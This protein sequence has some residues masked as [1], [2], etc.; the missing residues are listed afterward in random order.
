MSILPNRSLS[1]LR[2]RARQR[3]LSTVEYVIIL[4]LVAAVSLAT[5]K[6]FGERVKTAIGLSAARLDVLNAAQGGPAGDGSGTSGPGSGSGTSPGGPGAG[7]GG[8][9]NSTPSGPTV[10]TN[11]GSNID[12][13]VN[14]SPALAQDV[15]ALK[16]AGW[17]IRYTTGTRPAASPTRTVS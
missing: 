8:P 17:T 1:L 5:W 16:A 14:Q 2:R 7:P 12:A 9:R 10:T 15:Q 3:G 11:L 13:V 6:V 4:V